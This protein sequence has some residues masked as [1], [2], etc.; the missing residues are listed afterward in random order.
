MSTDSDESFLARWSRRK[1]SGEAE[2]D[3]KPTRAPPD[4]ADEPPFD[5]TKLPRIK[6]LTS[7]SDIAQFLQKGVPDELKRLALR[8][9][10]SLDPAISEFVE[11]A[12]NQYD[13]NVAGGVP[14]FGELD[15]G[16]DLKALLMQATGQVSEPPEAVAEV[17][18]VG[19][20]DDRSATA[21]A[22][23]QPGGAVSD[24]PDPDQAA[25]PDDS[26]PQ[27]PPLAHPVP[28]VLGS[29]S[30]DLA[31]ASIVPAPP[32]RARHGGALA[33]ITATDA[34]DK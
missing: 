33:C 14:G 19:E 24:Q 12:E 13:W 26:S 32:R 7:T 20:L 34:H 27:A 23:E 5:L 4:A 21:V 29:K 11:V 9:A 2:A 17:A 22:I 10:W 25:K 8:R 28:A 1:R 18:A 31:Q 16:T 15:A 30:A 6:D 3:A